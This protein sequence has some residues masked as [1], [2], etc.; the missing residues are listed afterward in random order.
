V[1]ISNIAMN[2]I[3]AP[4]FVRLGDR[5]RPFVEEGVRPG[6]GSLRDVTI[7][8]IEAIDAKNTGFAM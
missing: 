2:G 8:N 1:T 7:S 3:G 4:I 6:M 5:T